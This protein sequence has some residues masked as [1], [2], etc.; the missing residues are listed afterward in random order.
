MKHYNVLIATPGTSFLS[1]YVQSLTE[2][3]DECRNRG[4]TVKWLNGQSSLVHQARELTASGGGTSGLDPH[5]RSIGRDLTY[6]VVVWIDSDISWE[7]EDFFRLVDSKHEV[8]TGVYLVSNGATTVHAFGSR[9]GIP[10]QEILRMSE[11]IQVQSCGFGFVAM[12]RGVFE[13]MTRPWFTYEYSKV[14]TMQ[15]GTDVIDCIGEDISWCM[16]AQRKGIEIWFNPKVT[17]SH[18]K[19]VPLKFTK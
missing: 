11:P 5:Q 18:N 15:D 13:R 19:T 6:D 17:V 14:G 8:T 9:G 1:A 4:L 16:K 7:L 2:T 3:M 12:K 10:Q